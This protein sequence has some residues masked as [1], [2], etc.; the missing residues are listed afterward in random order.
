MVAIMITSR[1]IVIIMVVIKFIATIMIAMAQELAN[2]GALAR[3]QPDAKGSCQGKWQCLPLLGR[4]P[5]GCRWVYFDGGMLS[6]G[7]ITGDFQ[8]IRTRATMK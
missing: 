5:L 4:N 1:F 8:P 6:T 7:L 2:A 3:L